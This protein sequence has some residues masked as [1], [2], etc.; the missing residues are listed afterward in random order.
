MWCPFSF[1]KAPFG[2]FFVSAETRVFR[3]AE[4][5]LDYPRADAP[6]GGSGP[7]RRF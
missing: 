4:S 7:R 3:L 1:R 2:A 6:E 5:S